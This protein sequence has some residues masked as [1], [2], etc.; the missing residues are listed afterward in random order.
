MPIDP[1]EF[2]DEIEELHALVI[3]LCEIF[4]FIPQLHPKLS[5]ELIKVLEDEHHY[6]VLGRALG[7]LAWIGIICG[8][9]KTFS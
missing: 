4:C 9:V 3:G 1:R 5:V 7:L 8:I 2:L 6:Y